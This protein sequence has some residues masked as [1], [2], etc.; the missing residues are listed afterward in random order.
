MKIKLKTHEGTG[1]LA[2]SDTRAHIAMYTV[3]DNWNMIYI[4]ISFR[5]RVTYG[6]ALSYLIND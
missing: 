2:Q 1:R 6:G 4:I 3:Q 5:S